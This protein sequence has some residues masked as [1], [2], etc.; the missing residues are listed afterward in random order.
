MDARISLSEALQELRRELYSAQDAGAGQQLRFEVEQAQLTME[1]EFRR[2]GKGGVKVEVGLPGAKVNG[3]VGG[4]L[5]SISRQTLTLTLQVHDE[6]LG[7]ERAKINRAGGGLDD[8]DEL[9]AQSTG[10]ESSDGASEGPQGSM[11]RPW[12]S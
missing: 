8:V 4:G 3:D 9:Q 7:G 6:A 10:T 12:E 2:D 5:G 1:V 11:L